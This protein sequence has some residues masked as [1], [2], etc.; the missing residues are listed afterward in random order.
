M[1]PTPPRRVSTGFC[2]RGVRCARPGEE[3]VVVGVSQRRAAQARLR[4]ASRGRAGCADA[5]PDDYR[6]LL[7]R[8][9]VF[10]CAARRED[11]GRPSWRRS[12]TAACSSPLPRPDPTSR[13][14]IARELDARLVGE[15]LAGALRTA[16]D[17]PAPDYAER[18]LA[19][20][21]RHFAAL[22]S[23]GSSPRSYCRACLRSFE[24]SAHGRVLATSAAVS[25][26]RRAV[27]TPQ[28]ITVEALHAVGV[29]VDHD[30]SPRPAPPRGRGCRSGR[31]GRGWR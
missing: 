18:A 24:N 3:L 12:P 16:L 1:P 6:A 25:H 30:P 29:G 23:T 11:Y 20:R 19:R 5:A 14:P 27:A 28:R 31:A 4:A 9:R 8:A 22:R 26:A 21:S 17:D 15:D 10:V 13:L 7:R 2:A